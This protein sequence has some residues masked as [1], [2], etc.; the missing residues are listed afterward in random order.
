MNKLFL[1]RQAGKTRR[2][3][4][5]LMVLIGVLCLWA[6]SLLAG[7]TATRP[8]S[9]RQNGQISFFSPIM[10][11][12]S[13]VTLLAKGQLLIANRR[14]SDPNF[15]HTVILLL[16]FGREGSMGVVLNRPTDVGLAKVLPKIKALKKRKD[17]VYLGGPVGRD[18]I[19]LLAQSPQPPENSQQVFRQCYVVASQTALLHLIGNSN[20]NVKLRAFAG[21]A[22][23]ASGQLAAEVLRGDWYLLPAEAK[24]VFDTAPDNMWPELIKHSEFEWAGR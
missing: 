8:V 13:S 5:L 20:A 19:L 23:W 16:E 6:S 12:G 11:A 4:P 15:A 22:G 21:Y 18:Q 9:A 10:P 2:V 24:V 3:F 7:Q 14:L 17:M 1:V